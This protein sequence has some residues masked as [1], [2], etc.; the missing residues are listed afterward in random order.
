MSATSVLMVI[1]TTGLEYDDRL[2]KEVGS[3]QASGAR[4]SI[5]GLE[6]AN[7]AARSRVYEDVPAKTIRLRSRAWFPQGRGLVVKTAEMYLRFFANVAVAR[8]DVVWCHDLEMGALVPL[9]SILRVLGLVRRIVWDQHEL[10]ADGLRAQRGYR[11]LFR[12]LIDLCDVIVM[13]NAE[14][15]ALV[16][17]WLSDPFGPPIEVLNNYP[18]ATFAELP[19]RDLPADLT[20]WLAGTPYLLAQGGANPDRHLDALVAAIRRTPQFRLVVVGP[21]HAK[22][23]ERLQREHGAI[24]AQVRFTGPVPQMELARYIDHAYAS[25]IL[26]QAQSSNTILCAP[27]R[28]YQALVRRVPVIVGSNPPMA[29]VV[30]AFGCGVVLDGDGGNIDDLC[31]A[32]RQL[33]AG[34][35]RLKASAAISRDLTWGSQTA[36]VARIAGVVE[37]AAGCTSTC[38]LPIASDARIQRRLAALAKLGVRPTVLAF[39]R[40]SYPGKPVPGG[41]QSLGEVQHGRYLSRLRPLLAAFLKVRAACIDTDVVY[42]FSMDLLAL[43]WLAT[44]ASRRRPRLIYEVADIHPTLVGPGLRASMMRAIERRLLRDTSLLV[45]TSEAFITGFYREIQGLHGSAIRAGRE[46]AGARSRRRTAVAAAR[47]AAADHDR[48]FRGPAVRA[49]VAGAAAHRR[50]RA[51]ADPHLPPRRSAEPADVRRGAPP[52]AVDRLRRSLRRAR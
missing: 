39:E 17:D 19:V 29:E 52:G 4:V 34:Y 48:V 23:V 12:R 33:E 26:Y 43:A 44:R 1:N 8:P 22:V 9:L 37:T 25:V 5:L 3:L 15:R 40:P 31:R 11:W 21:Y 24:D 18:D 13:A 50:G 45:V 10:P 36:T 49:L 51:G 14:R 32:M 42:A 28:L 35:A 38:L 41:Y 47:H 6:Y 16:L 2:R 7:R 30:N 46:Q 20:A 27:N